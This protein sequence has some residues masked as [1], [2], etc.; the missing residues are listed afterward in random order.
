M[1]NPFSSFDERAVS[2]AFG[3][4]ERTSRFRRV[5]PGEKLPPSKVVWD[6]EDLKAQPPWGDNIA[7][8]ITSLGNYFVSSTGRDVFALLEEALDA[9]A[10]EKSDATIG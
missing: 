7:S 8:E 9:S 6:I 5:S 2:G 3:T 4:S 10:Q 1:G